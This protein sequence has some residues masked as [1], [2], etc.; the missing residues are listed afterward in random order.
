MA[1]AAPGVTAL[2]VYAVALTTLRHTSTR[3]AT[4][5]FSRGLTRVATTALTFVRSPH[6]TPCHPGGADLEARLEAGDD[7]AFDG[8]LEEI[9]DGLHE[10]LVL[11]RYE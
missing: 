2:A 11:D 5:T 1:R 9:L 3:L 7:L 8:L 10:I 6:E 4:A